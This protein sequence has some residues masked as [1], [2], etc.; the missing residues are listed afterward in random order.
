MWPRKLYLSVSVG[1]IIGTGRACTRLSVFLWF[2]RLRCSSS[3]IPLPLFVLL[4][5]LACIPLLLF[6]FF[7]SS[8]FRQPH[9]PPHPSPVRVCTS[10]AEQGRV[11]RRR[12]VGRGVSSSTTQVCVLV[13]IVS[14]ML[15][16]YF[17]SLF[18]LCLVS[19]L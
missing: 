17:S 5:P 9:Y 8:S 3:C 15:R 18:G 2:E 10:G 4:C 11:G 1:K 14:C 7:H 16:V 19:V 12:D 13:Q 6:L